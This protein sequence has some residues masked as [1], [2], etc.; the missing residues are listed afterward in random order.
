[1]GDGAVRR[2]VYPEVPPKVEYS[3]TPYGRTLR[4]IA[5]LMCAWG[6]QHLRRP[7]LGR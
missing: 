7:S 3:P 4:E 1:L 5:D 2:E 6:K